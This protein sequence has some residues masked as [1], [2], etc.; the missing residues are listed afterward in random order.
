MQPQAKV[1]E[2]VTETRQA[3]RVDE[4]GV[5]MSF[6]DRAIVATNSRGS[7]GREFTVEPDKTLKGEWKRANR[8]R[9]PTCGRFN[10]PR[11][12]ASFGS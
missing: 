3:E 11:Y 4:G 7:Y 9:C 12:L 8:V 2:L 5:V 1:L 6:L 10:C